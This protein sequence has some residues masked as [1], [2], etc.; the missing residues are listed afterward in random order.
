[1]KKDG[2]TC[3]TGLKEN[4]IDKE[5]FEREVFLC[6]KESKQEG[7]GCGWGRCKTCGVVPLLF[8]NEASEEQKSNLLCSSEQMRKHT[9]ETVWGLYKLHKGKIIEDEEVKEL[10]GKLDIG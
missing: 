1:M 6:Q 10:K 4:I 5:V 8:S 9:P 2:I 3:K 7:G